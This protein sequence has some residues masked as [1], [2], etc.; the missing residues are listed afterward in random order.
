MTRR[1]ALNA[2]R[3]RTRKEQLA[4]RNGLR[5]AYCRRPFVDLHEATLDH[6]APYSLWRTW[7]ATALVLACW[8]CNHAKSDRLFL[9][10]ALLLIWS[11]D[12]AYTGV[13]ST[14]DPIGSVFTDADQSTAPEPI[15]LGPAQVDWLMLARIVHARSSA[16]QSTPDQTKPIKPTDR[17]VRIGRL[18]HQRR[19][20]RM[21]ACEQST[22][23]GVSA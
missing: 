14:G 4:R 12:P 2:E 11:T 13:Q 19:R 5:C 22:D 3:R 21:N 16:E 9:S 15:R 10:I 7:S 18:D 23:R 6:V 17:R 1:Q 8:P 20:A